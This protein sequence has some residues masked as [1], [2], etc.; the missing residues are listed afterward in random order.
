MVHRGGWPEALGNVTTP[1]V[2]LNEHPSGIVAGGRQPGMPDVRDEERDIARC[3]DQ[4]YCPSA[5]PLQIAIGEPIE[6]WRL[7]RGMASRYDSRRARLK[8]AVPQENVSRNGKDRI[9]DA[10][11]PG[12][13]GVSGDVWSGVDVPE[14]PQVFVVA[15]W[16]PPRSVGDNVAV[17][18]EERF[19][20]PENARI[21]DGALDE[22]TPVEHFVTERCHSL[23]VVVGISHIRCVLRKDPLHVRVEGSQGRRSENASQHRVTLRFEVL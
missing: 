3:G 2:A 22:G 23:R 19:D 9:G 8:R 7:S 4:G 20:C 5:I 12:N 14:P 16:L 15:R 17:L 11:V 21:A 18:A 6:W 1:V 10:F 13:V